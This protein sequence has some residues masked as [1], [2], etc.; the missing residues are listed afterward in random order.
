MI[1][2]VE[3]EATSVCHHRVT[4]LSSYTT[5]ELHGGFD[6]VF[7]VSVY[8]SSQKKHLFRIGGPN[9]QSFGEKGPV[10]G[11]HEQQ[12]A[13]NESRN[14]ALKI[15]FQPEIGRNFLILT[16]PSR[17]QY[18]GKRLLIGWLNWNSARC[19]T[20]QVFQPSSGIGKLYL[21]GVFNTCLKLIYV[22]FKLKKAAIIGLRS[23][24]RILIARKISGILAFFC[25]INCPYRVVCTTIMCPDNRT[26]YFR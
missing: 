5:V 7:V 13:P 16:L 18:Y 11:C 17:N 6:S 20:W 24:E 25:P 2:S 23:G 21:I 10:P 12:F 15:P 4:C 22:S 14:S 3:K 9:T 19:T 26:V 8:K 1:E